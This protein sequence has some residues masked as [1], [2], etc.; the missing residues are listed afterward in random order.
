VLA[1]R[2]GLKVEGSMRTRLARALRDGARDRGESIDA[3][4]RTLLL[5]AD[6]R[7]GLVDRITVQETRFFRDPQHFETL[8]RVVLPDAP[9]V[10]IVWSAGCAN[11]QE[12]WSLAMAL[13]EAGASGWGVVATDVAEPAL[14]RTREGVY[15]ERELL[16]LSPARRE[17]Y[18]RRRADGRFAI[19]PALRDRVRTVAHNLLDP[20]PPVVAGSCR[21]V[22]C[23]NV[24]IYLDPAATGKA[25]DVVARALVPGGWLFV[26]GAEVVS[27][28]KGRAFIPE[29]HGTSF[30]YRLAGRRADAPAA[31]PPGPARARREPPAAAPGGTDPRA[32]APVGIAEDGG[33]PPPAAELLARGE[34]HAAAG[35]FDDAAAAFRQA[36]YLEPDDWSAHLRLGLAL[37]HR[38][39]RTGAERAFRAAR[40][41]LGRAPAGAE[42][43]GWSRAEVLR[44]LETRL[45]AP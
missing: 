25:L 35:E 39:G 26:G 14:R 16:G 21:V 41:A 2:I 23:R 33:P 12:P 4:V 22:F 3:Y 37:E 13:D 38:E 8:G 1:E 10:G 43:D 32:A 44:L 20:A 27:G 18:L 31:P 15:A 11:G 30:A 36:A 7:Q 24:L 45:G 6:S 17:R 42:L 29:R 34:R 28:G 40:A 5:D 9:D 19:V